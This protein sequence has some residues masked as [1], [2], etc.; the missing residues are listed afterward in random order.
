M[1]DRPLPEHSGDLREHR[2]GIARF[3][4]SLSPHSRSL[5]LL[6]II[7]LGF[8]S[9][10][11]PDTILGVAWKRMQKE[12]ELPVYYAGILSMV[13]TCCSAVSS[14]CSGMLLRRLSTGRLLM[15]CG[16]MTGFFLL[17]YALS[18]AFW[19]LLLLTVPLGLGQGA[20]DTGMNFYVA[21][22]YTSRDMNWLHCC[23]GIGASAGPCLITAIL[24][25]GGSWRWG[26]MTVGTVQISLALLF[27]AAL[28]LWKDAPGDGD[29]DAAEQGAYHGRPRFSLRFWCC[30]AMFFLY[31]GVEVSLGLWGYLFLT[32][33]RGISDAAAG[34]TVAGYWGML[35]LGRFAMGIFANRLGNSRQARWSMA[36]VM[37]GGLLLAVPGVVWLPFVALGLLG[38]SLAPFYPAMMHAAPERFDDATACTLIGFQGGGAM[39]GIATIP[40]AFG[41]LASK[42]T[43][44][45]LPWL[46][47]GLGLLIWLLLCQVDGG[48]TRRR[49]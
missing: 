1:P 38:F 21:K 48:R 25:A 3:F 47:F 22:H 44:A 16:F 31:T 45:W 32:N 43:F 34:F 28:G 39:I 18:P 11:L 10:G 26:Y 9:L 33:C 35:T 13:L 40:P 17:G 6:G 15:I 4:R 24:A 27:L 30:A 41:Y 37:A 23:W 7:Y 49:K 8:I 5:I 19:V 29:S 42:T 20:V 46:A 14:F 2:S 36:G 12:L